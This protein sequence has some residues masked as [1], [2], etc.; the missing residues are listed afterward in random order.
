MGMA[1]KFLGLFRVTEQDASVFL[2]VH[3]RQAL[4]VATEQSS[5][6]RPE[7]EAE[8]ETRLWKVCAEAASPQLSKFEWIAILVFAASALVAM[9]CCTFEW[10]QLSNTGSLDQVVRALLTR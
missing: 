4:R 8:P 6:S 9:A 1:L 3:G 7:V 10:L 2:S 5:L